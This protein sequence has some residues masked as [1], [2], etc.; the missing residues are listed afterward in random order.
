MTDG[1]AGSIIFRA[2]TS[3]D[4]AFILDSWGSSY[5]KGCSV[6]KRLSPN[7][8]H[9]FHRPQ[10][11][12]FFSKPNTTCIVASPSD[13]PWHIMGWIAVEKIASGLIL[14]Y[15][16]V[17]DAFKNQKIAQQLIQRALPT[18]PVFYTHITERAAK[19]MARKGEFF[20]AFKHVPHLV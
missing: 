9:E 1:E 18:Q 15:V 7:E 12:R 14:H 20:S 4:L 10:R 11:M 8:F 13:D 2:H 6:H 19:I 17:K 5:F 16:Y 3:E